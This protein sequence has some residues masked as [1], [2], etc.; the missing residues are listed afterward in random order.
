MEKSVYKFAKLEAM[1]LI[2]DKSQPTGQQQKATKS[3]KFLLEI[4]LSQRFSVLKYTE[5]RKVQCQSCLPHW[6]VDQN[7]GYKHTKLRGM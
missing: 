4:I 6:D 1:G 7:I 5:M 3:H 2:S